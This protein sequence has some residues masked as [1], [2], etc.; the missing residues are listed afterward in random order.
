MHITQVIEQI[1]PTLAA[2]IPQDNEVHSFVAGWR[3]RYD[4]YTPVHHKMLEAALRFCSD[5]LKG[6]PPRWLTFLGP[7]GTGKTFLLEQCL[8][9]LH[10]AA[11][12]R[13]WRVWVVEG[14]DQPGW[15]TP[16]H[17][18]VIPARDLD[19]HWSP[20]HF[21]SLDLC[22]VEDLGAGAS[23]EKGSGKVLRDRVME[24]MQLRS[25]GW[26]MACANLLLEDI[27]AHFDGRLASRLGRDGS[28]FIEL[29]KDTPDYSF[30]KP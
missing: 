25:R 24:L 21:A 2:G 30:R 10:D 16:T 23:M 18:R 1:R 11:M 27:E 20:R 19:S 17:W 28:V 14:R 8:Q 4:C 9:C 12:A 3:W 15:G 13:E 29:P 22:Y 5:A 7:S 6:R 26:T